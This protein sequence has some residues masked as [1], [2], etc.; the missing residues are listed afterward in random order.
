MQINVDRQRGAVIV[1]PVGRIDS[2]TSPSLDQHLLELDSAGERRIVIDLAGV[3]YI[4]SAGLRVISLARRIREHK[5]SLAL[6]ALAGSVLRVFE[7]AGL[8]SLFT[9][10]ASCEEAVERVVTSI[11]LE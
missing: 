10:A 9:V 4:S 6:C 3:D 5:G 8:L 7:L 2:T 1:A 11:A